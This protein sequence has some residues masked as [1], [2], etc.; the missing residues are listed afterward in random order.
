M[1]RRLRM[2]CSAALATFRSQRRA[3]KVYFRRTSCIA[4]AKSMS[5]RET[6]RKAKPASFDSSSC[7][8]CLSRFFSKCGVRQESRRR[9]SFEDDRLFS[10]LPHK[11]TGRD[12]CQFDN[13][14]HTLLLSLL[15]LAD[16][17]YMPTPPLRIVCILRWIPHPAEQGP[18]WLI[19]TPF[20]SVACTETGD[21]RP[22][23][24]T[25]VSLLPPLCR[26]R[27]AGLVAL[28]TTRYGTRPTWSML[29]TISL[30][31]SLSLHFLTSRI[32]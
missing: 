4:L 29:G 6:L 10:S 26:E 1:S 17:V 2:S 16:A 31:L 12:N 7:P 14:D 15:Q 27:T 11:Q 22:D 23:R 9:R 18:E 13:L 21:S 25:S 8:T 24:G 3:L 20:A 28:C 32:P 30:S 19:M 5:R